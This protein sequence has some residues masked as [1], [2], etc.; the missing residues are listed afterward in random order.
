MLYNKRPLIYI[1]KKKKIVQSAPAPTPV[2]AAAA[3]RV[4]TQYLK[5]PNNQHY[6]INNWQYPAMI[7][8]N[9]TTI[10]FAINGKQHTS[11]LVSGTRYSTLIVPIVEQ[12]G[13]NMVTIA[14]GMRWAP[15]PPEMLTSSASESMSYAFF[16]GP[17]SHN[18]FDQLVL[19]IKD[20]TPTQSDPYILNGV[21]I[22]EEAIPG[23]ST[24][25]FYYRKL[26]DPNSVIGRIRIA[27]NNTYGSSIGTLIFTDVG[28]SLWNN[29][30]LLSFANYYA[31]ALYGTKTSVAD[32]LI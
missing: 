5:Y 19:K 14:N 21:M 27:L 15:V 12:S 32:L 26:Y 24:P 20:S 25:Q 7:E 6:Y 1:P 28:Y 16:I 9:P 10:A 30:T 29:A 2:E 22:R 4:L 18:P 8:F 23:M 31:G 3:I 17:N 13:N 11:T